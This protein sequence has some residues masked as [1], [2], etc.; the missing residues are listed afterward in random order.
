MLFKLYVLELK[1]AIKK[2]TDLETEVQTLKS[3][4]KTI[5]TE[6]MERSASK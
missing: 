2:I 1:A 6:R 5:T 3:E 4:V